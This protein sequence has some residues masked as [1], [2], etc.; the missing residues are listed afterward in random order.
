MMQKQ[1]VILR[2]S[3]IDEDVIVQKDSTGVT[4]SDDC[5]TEFLHFS[6]VA[7]LDKFYNIVKELLNSD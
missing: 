5:H 2:D 6:N 7:D 3:R 1:G 4:C